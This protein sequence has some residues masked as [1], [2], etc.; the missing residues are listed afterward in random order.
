MLERTAADDPEGPYMVNI[1]QFENAAISMD[2]SKPKKVALHKLLQPANAVLPICS[3]DSGKVISRM[4]L[5]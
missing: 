1:S 5:P 2:V 3:T 4:P